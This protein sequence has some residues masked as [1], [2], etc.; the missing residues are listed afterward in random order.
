MKFYYDKLEFSTEEKIDFL[1]TLE[2]IGEEETIKI[3]HGIPYIDF[4]ISDGKDFNIG[5]TVLTVLAVSTL[6]NGEIYAFPYKKS[7]GYSE[8]QPDAQ[9]WREFFSQKDLYL[10][11]GSYTVTL[12]PSFDIQLP[13][14]KGTSGSEA[15]VEEYSNS[16]TIEIVV[17]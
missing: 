1:A 6:N 7:G 3:Q 5:G 11:A 16:I 8:D 15:E 13:S 17:K 2:Y 10:P 4:L 14:S 12:R 9:F